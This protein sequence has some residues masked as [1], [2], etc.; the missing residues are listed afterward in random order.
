SESLKSSLSAN[1]QMIFGGLVDKFGL[2]LLSGQIK[3]GEVVLSD[4][5]TLLF[6][7][8][9]GAMPIGNVDPNIPSFD[10]AL[11]AVYTIFAIILHVPAIDT[12]E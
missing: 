8:M 1:T 7:T 5:L 12:S 9:I 10:K 4:V 3:D 2:R 11:A 6:S